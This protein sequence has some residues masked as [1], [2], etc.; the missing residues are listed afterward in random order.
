[1]AWNLPTLPTAGVTVASA[2]NWATKVID[3]LR[4]LKGLDGDIT[5]ED[6]IL[7][8]YLIDGVDISAHKARHESGGAD[9]FDAP[10][11]IDALPN[12]TN[13]KYWQGNGSNRPA[14]L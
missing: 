8:A 2:A 6:D 4:F 5:F 7:T 14:E 11:S 12:L 1:M 9:A 13:G 10:L 3:S